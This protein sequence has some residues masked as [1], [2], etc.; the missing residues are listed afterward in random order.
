[1]ISKNIKILGKKFWP[2]FYLILLT[3]QWWNKHPIKQS[4]IITAAAKYTHVLEL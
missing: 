1:M 4:L 3:G 2:G